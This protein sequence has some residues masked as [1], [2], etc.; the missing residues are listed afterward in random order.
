MTFGGFTLGFGN[1][2]TYGFASLP[3]LGALLIGLIGGI[4][5]AHRQ[6]KAA[7]PFLDLRVL[8][9][10]EYALSVFGSILLYLVLMGS[11]MLMPLYVQSILGK[12]ATIS[13]LVVLPGSL[14]S[15]FLSPIAGRIY[16]KVGIRI[17]TI[18]GGSSLVLSNIGMF[19]FIY[20][21]E[22]GWRSA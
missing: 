14:V 15:A 8:K 10:K 3:V 9:T 12:S 4:L 16:D 17:I 2:G 1:L 7:V 5:F 11:S 20:T 18:I 21:Q 13:G 6:M 22:F 19:L